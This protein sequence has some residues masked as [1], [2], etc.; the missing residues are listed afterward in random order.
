MDVQ[1][2]DDNRFNLLEVTI[3]N[4]KKVIKLKIGIIGGGSIGLLFGAYL[5]RHNDIT[6]F[7]S[8]TEQAKALGQKGITVL[9]I[10]E[11]LIE[12][13]KASADFA[14]LSVQ[15]IVFVAVKQ[16]DL[17]SLCPALLKIPPETPLCF[18]QN[19]MGHLKLLAD[20]PHT[21]IFVG[22]VEHGAK[23]MD[24]T[25]VHHNGI[26]KTNIAL[27]RGE[28]DC[29]ESFPTMD[30]RSFRFTF[31]PN[32]EQ[33][34]LSKLMTNALINPLTAVLQV[35]NGRLVDNKYYY[36]VFQQLFKEMIDIFPQLDEEKLFQEI[37]GI[38]ENTKG[39]TS[40]MLKD[41]QSGKNTEVEAILGYT[42]EVANEK[43]IN[44]VTINMLY[45]MVKGMEIERG[46]E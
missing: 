25:S 8:G 24:Y 38:C 29:L 6:I 43:G 26:G 13:V 14:H 30:H 10:K 18:I 33:M 46:E 7:T 40:S 34:L 2:I 11:P 1:Y 45:L 21:C 36:Q 31:Q 17:Q 15:D 22:T 42:L 44:P 12:K 16:Y 4:L 23:R 41:I 9:N 37:K 27:F 3:R 39:N 19:G 32:F 5:S 20:L 28:P 35:N